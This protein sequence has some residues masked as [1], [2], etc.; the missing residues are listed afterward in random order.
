VDVAVLSVGRWEDYQEDVQPAFK[1][2]V[3]DALGQ[4]IPNTAALD[5][6]RRDTL[7]I[8]TKLA[9][10]GASLDNT[11]GAQVGKDQTA[12]QLPT[13]ATTNELGIDPFTKYRAA[14]ALYQQVKLINRYVKDAAISENYTPYLVRLQ[15]SLMP[16]QRG[17]PWD[18][19]SIIS[20]FL[21]PLEF[22]P[23]DTNAALGGL[24]NNTVDKARRSGIKVI[25]LLASDDLEAMMQDRSLDRIRQLNLA[26][27]ALIKGASASAE[28]QK[29][30]ELLRSA[31]SRDFNSTFTIARLWD[32][33]LMCRFGA[34]SQPQAKAND[35]QYA[36]IPQTHE[37]SVLVMVPDDL[38]MCP[39]EDQRTVNVWVRTSVYDIKD[40]KEL[41]TR[42][43]EEF[44]DECRRVFESYSLTNFDADRDAMELTR[45][46]SRNDYPSFRAKAW[47][48]SQS[49]IEFPQEFWT[50]FLAIR[51]R[52]P[53]AAATFT[54]PQKPSFGLD[55]SMWP[56]TNKP[57]LLDD[58]RTAATITL[59]GSGL[60]QPQ[61]R[62]WLSLESKPYVFPADSMK[63]LEA[64]RRL[65]LS[66]P[67]LAA[68]DLAPSDASRA[69]TNADV[70][71]GLLWGFGK[72]KSA[73]C[74]ALSNITCAHLIAPKIPK[75]GFSISSQA[76]FLNV[77]KDRGSI[78]LVF[79]GKTAEA[80]V[81]FSIQGAD[82]E[83]VAAETKG[84]F[85]QEDADGWSVSTNGVVWAELKNLNPLTPVIVSAMDGSNKAEHTPLVIPVLCQGRQNS[86]AGP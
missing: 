30:H 26:L 12:S 1:M 50:D 65:V 21:G 2:S 78:R 68:Y 70:K 55:C 43:H 6:M 64:G 42:T 17:Q 41:R 35:A 22:G 45:I 74:N 60:D 19:Y 61:L 13:R 66:F 14:T 56:N 57:V 25:P 5:E 86:G 79:S 80:K 67:S 37:V 81:R 75:A 28:V 77:E 48:L 54:V 9:F 24:S 51:N 10:P 85:V 76:R 73:G 7:A 27:S 52:C 40:K 23:L 18:A 84:L 47:A 36:M 53:Y 63:V 11:K 32:N 29:A 46:A 15:V 4:S 16:K 62:A 39:D 49:K 44:V 83:H 31:L 34:S 8:T 3:E 69:G 82:V 59:T 58:G 33:T 38:A 20:F 72:S 71:L